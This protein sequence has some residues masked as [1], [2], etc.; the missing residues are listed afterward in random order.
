[1]S[2]HASRS[3]STPGHHSRVERLR[4]H[5]A[6]RHHHQHA[7]RRRDHHRPRPADAQPAQRAPA[8]A[9]SN[10]FF[11]T[12]TDQVEKQVEASMGIR[13]APVRRA[14]RVH[15]VPV[16]PVR[17]LARAHPDAR[18]FSPA[19]GVRPQPDVRAGDLRDLTMHVAGSARRAS[20]GTTR[21]LFEKPRVLFP[22]RHHRGAHQAGHARPATLRQHLRRRDHGRA[23]RGAARLHPLAARRHLEAV[24]R[25]HRAHPGVHLRPA[26][27]PV[28]ELGRAAEEGRRDH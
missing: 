17:E 28:L 26:D 3:T 7:D 24:R 22:L 21:H 13:T 25:V 18:E 20:A 19:A 14:A 6:R 27:H 2:T 23:D 16:H 9:G 11:E 15:A 8:R 10:S 12:V 5:A 1:M 4:P